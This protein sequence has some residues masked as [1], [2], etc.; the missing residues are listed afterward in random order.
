MI[1]ENY[2]VLAVLIVCGLTSCF[3]DKDEL[4]GK[5][6]VK[7]SENLFVK[8]YQ[9][10]KFDYVTPILFELINQDGTVIISKMFL[11]GTDV[12]HE[13]IERFYPFLHD[14][15][16]YICY[17]YPEVYAIHHLNPAKS[18]LPKDT[19]FKMI[20]ENDSKLIYSKK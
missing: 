2:I 17:P 13:K 11:T 10:D 1:K 14:S 6:K 3:S 9:Q 7:G 4:I 12:R 15:I 8:I 18:E 20:K 5:K 19:L 16:F